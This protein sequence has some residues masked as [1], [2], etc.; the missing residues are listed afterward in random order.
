MLLWLVN[1]GLLLVLLAGYWLSS[2]SIVSSIVLVLVLAGYFSLLHFIRPP[3]ANAEVAPRQPELDISKIEVS[4]S[5]LA[6]GSA[7]VSFF[8][9][10]LNNEIK[11]SAQ[12][13]SQIAD[14]SSELSHT[15]R[16]L[17]DSLQ[18]LNQSIQ[19]TASA[20]QQA[21]KQLSSSVISLEQLASS[22]SHSAEELEQLRSSADNIQRITE[23]INNVADQTNLLALNAAIE[24]A[25]AGE[26]GRGFAVV[27]E[28][29]R[30]LASKTSGATADIAKMLAEI[31]QQSGQTADQMS[32]L[33][34]KSSEV[35]QQL[36]QVTTGFTNI[37]NEITQAAA[38]SDQLESAGTRLAQTSTAITE[39][40]SNISG[41]LNAIEHK[42]SSI[43]NQ[44]IDLSMETESIYRELS[45]LEHQSF[46]SPILDEA[47]QAAGVIA[48]LLQQGI[49]SGKFTEQQ[50]F[51]RD[52][53]PIANTDPQKFHTAYDNYT[54]QVFPQV[55]EPIL[56]R[57]SQV[58][59][60]GAVD[61]KGYFPTHNKKFSQP[62]SGDYNKDLLANRS[63]RIF[64][65][66]TGSR[67]GSNTEAML[68]QTYKRDTG[69][70]L[71]D[72]SVPIF[73]NGKHWGG[74]RIGFKR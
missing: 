17:N 9:D 71:H 20:C 44:A 6:I 49:N 46:Y 13:S 7:E 34:I 16:Q 54:D 36:Q 50:L 72:L 41:G 11:L 74:F 64:A 26:Q 12:N 24:A 3:T 42:G 66:R 47:L 60:A 14:N 31:R 37:N 18:T 65:D 30:A 73:V 51:A 56:S 32:L 67:C 45:Q 15:G 28:E 39:A 52:Y 8:I 55:Q 27:A 29:V 59:Y 4:T 61:R 70:I 63:K 68:L 2:A 1:L 40:I 10:S 23:V 25:R 57:H 62:L 58:L 43:A 5:R 48:S 19:H 53:Q 69:E 33:V 21:D 35:Q 38:A 22:V